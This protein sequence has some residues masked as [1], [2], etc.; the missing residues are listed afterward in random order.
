M[1]S[2]FSTFTTSKY[3]APDKPRNDLIRTRGKRFVAASEADDSSM[4]IDTA[5]LKKISGNDD[6]SVRGNFQ[7]EI[8]YTPQAKVFLRMNNE[9]RILDGTD[10]TWDRVKK[11]NFKR[12]F[13]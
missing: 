9:P 5:L 12:Q 3:S 1:D 4:R 13:S 2:S 7:Q 11:I 10:S 8:E 6:L